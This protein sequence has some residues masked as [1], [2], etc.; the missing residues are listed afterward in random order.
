MYRC[1]AIFASIGFTFCLLIFFCPRS[2]P[3]ICSHSTS[4]YWIL[5]QFH[6]D[7]C[8][9]FIL[10]AYLRKAWAPGLQVSSL[11]AVF[12]SYE[13]RMSSLGALAFIEIFYSLLSQCFQ[14]LYSFVISHFAQRYICNCSQTQEV[15]LLRQREILRKEYEF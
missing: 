7:V 5:A 10:E 2:L 8:S 15:K 9:T 4:F 11:L 14:I 12:P 6:Q 1:P 3:L 13:P